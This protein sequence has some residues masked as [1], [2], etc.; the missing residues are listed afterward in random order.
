MKNLPVACLGKMAFFQKIIQLGPVSLDFRKVFVMS[1]LVFDDAIKTVC[2][3]WQ[4]NWTA[5]ILA[6]KVIAGRYIPLF[7]CL[8]TVID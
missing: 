1:F 5:L 2:Q 3:T 4:C 7:G 6:R 8:Q